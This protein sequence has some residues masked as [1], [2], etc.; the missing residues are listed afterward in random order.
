VGD[1]TARDYE[2]AKRAGLKPLLIDREGK[3]L[4]NVDSIK[5]LTEV[6]LYF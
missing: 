3:A 2:G 4:Q 1:S 6:L 5:S